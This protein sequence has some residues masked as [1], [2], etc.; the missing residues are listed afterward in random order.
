[1]RT[2]QDIIEGSTSAY[3]PGRYQGDVLLVQASE[4]LHMDLLPPWRDVISPN[5]HTEYVD[6]HHDDLM[7]AHNVGDVGEV[8]RKY[9]V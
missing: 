8:I 2:T 7:K 5:L 1:M 6:G 4:R 3:H 9:I